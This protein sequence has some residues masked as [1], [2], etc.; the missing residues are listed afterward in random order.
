MMVIVLCPFKLLLTI[1]ND[2]YL[3]STHTFITIV[4][5]KT[6]GE[7]SSLPIFGPKGLHIT[8]D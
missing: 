1:K 7:N 2:S 8:W 4:F 3:P 6:Y 5:S